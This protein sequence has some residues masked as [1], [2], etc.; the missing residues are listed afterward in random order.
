MMT[1]QNKVKSSLK[2]GRYQAGTNLIEVMVALLILSVGLLGLAMLQ[3]Q[4]LKYNSDS[5]LR[6]QATF[7][8]NEIIERMR[9]NKTAAASYTNPI[10]TSLSKNCTTANC[11]GSELALFDLYSWGQTLKNPSTGL[12]NVSTSISAVSGNRYLVSIT[13]LE[14]KAAGTGAAGADGQGYEGLVT[15][16]WTVDL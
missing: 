4:G 5:Y 3:I 7:L 2:T 8:A 6:T 9:V 15:Q 14:Q 10:P 13:W 11:N 1:I 16:T 12:P